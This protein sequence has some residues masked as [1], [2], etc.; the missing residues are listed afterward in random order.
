MFKKIITYLTEK[1]KQKREKDLNSQF[2][3]AKDHADVERILR[4]IDRIRSSGG[5]L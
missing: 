4:K 5:I 2:R 3:D 1:S